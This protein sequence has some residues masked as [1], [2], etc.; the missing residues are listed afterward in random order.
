[1]SN[2]RGDWASA[3][4][5]LVSAASLVGWFYLT[6]LL[7]LAV[8]VGATWTA[9]GWHPMVVTT[10]DLRPTVKPGDVLLVGDAGEGSLASGAVVTAGRP[11]GPQVMMIGDVT[12]QG[13]YLVG[14]DIEVQPDEVTGVGRLLVPAL[15]SPIVWWRDDRVG[16]LLLTVIITAVSVVLTAGPMVARRRN[17]ERGSPMHGHS[18]WTVEPT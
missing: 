18:P 3:G 15:G 9:L 2:T 6:L 7:W 10:E 16:L 11:E 13:T 4:V 17:A 5:R 12:P 1:L 8:W 14:D